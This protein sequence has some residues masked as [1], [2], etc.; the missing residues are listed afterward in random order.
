MSNVINPD[1]SIR[2]GLSFARGVAME[3]YISLEDE[4]VLHERW[5]STW[6]VP[7]MFSGGVKSVTCE[8]INEV[9]KAEFTR[10]YGKARSKRWTALASQWAALT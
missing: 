3:Q 5:K 10:T 2:S 6:P 9:P 8:M 4:L 7:L 1:V